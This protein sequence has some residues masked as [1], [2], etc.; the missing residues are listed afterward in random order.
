MAASPPTAGGSRPG[1]AR[2]EGGQEALGRRIRV[3]QLARL[4]DAEDRIRILVRELGQAPFRLPEPLALGALD[5]L[6]LRIPTGQ[7]E[8]MVADDV[9]DLIRAAAVERVGAEGQDPV[10]A[11]DLIDRGL[12]VGEGLPVLFFEPKRVAAEPEAVEAAGPGPF[13]LAGPS[14]KDPLGIE[15]AS[16]D[17]PCVVGQDL[18]LAVAEALFETGHGLGQ[19]PLR[20]FRIDGFRSDPHTE[21]V[22]LET[23]GEVGH[24]DVQEIFG[25][26]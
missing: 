18:H 16:G 24:E 19:G 2:A 11:D 5:D 26:L 6:P 17:V 10:L 20:G 4:V 9:E 13:E 3:E 25:V 12:I 21:F 7:G 22:G 8:T 23:G 14:L 15:A 1:T